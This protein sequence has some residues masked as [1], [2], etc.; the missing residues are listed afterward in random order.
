MSQIHEESCKPMPLANMNI[1]TAW[2]YIKYD[3]Q[4]S[5]QG[6]CIRTESS[7][8]FYVMSP[9]C[10]VVKYDFTSFMHVTCAKCILTW[11]T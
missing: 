3:G 8:T 11:A 5:I 9:Y 4:Q 7:I 10:Y 6:I 1:I 2:H